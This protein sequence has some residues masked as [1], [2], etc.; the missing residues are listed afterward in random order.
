MAR[1]RKKTEETNSD[2]FMQAF[3]EGESVA[4]EAPVEE[5]VKE[6]EPT[7]EPVKE[8]QSVEESKP[9]STLEAVK[10]PEPTPE[11]VKEP[12]LV[13]EP[14][15]K[16][17]SLKK[18]SVSKLQKAKE[19]LLKEY[20]EAVE[21][22]TELHDGDVDKGGAPYWAHP[23][24]VSLRAKNIA[25]QAKLDEKVAIL[26]ALLHDVVEDGKTTLKQIEARFGAEV[27]KVVGI[28]TRDPK[29]SYM[30]YVKSIVASG[31]KMALLVKWADLIHNT[32]PKRMKKLVELDRARLSK[33]YDTALKLVEKA[34]PLLKKAGEEVTR[35]R[36]EAHHA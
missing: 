27:A 22:M 19:T 26:A 14:A 34:W 1:K 18:A 29:M 23:L 30:E 2:E 17:K 28:L 25:M 32:N 36:K 4:S 3:M 20:G 12:E 7:P 21:W 9:E 10:E 16:T 33:K 31:S 13:K 6:P 11:P 24:M 15:K 5:P 35:N 8:P